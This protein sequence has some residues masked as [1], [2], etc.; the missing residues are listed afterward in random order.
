M[1]VLQAPDALALEPGV[2]L[3]RDEDALHHRLE[4]QVELDRRALRDAENL[5]A[6][7][8]GC[9]SREAGPTLRPRAAAELASV[10]HERRSRVETHGSTP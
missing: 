5:D 2:C 3:A 9:R 10:E 7:V 8:C 4:P 1:D 6:K